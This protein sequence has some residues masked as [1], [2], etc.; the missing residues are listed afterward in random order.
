VHLSGAVYAET[1][2]RDAG[3]DQLC[4]DPLALAFT[5]PT[6]NGCLTNAVP[7]AQVP[8]NQHLYD[9]LID[10]FSMRS[11]VPTPG[12]S[13]HDHFFDTFAKFTG[14]DPK[15]IGEWI[16]EVAARAASQNEQYLELMDTPEFSHA[17][18]LSHQVPWNDDLAAY[19][20]ALLAA[21]LRDEVAVD[22]AHYD[23]AEATRNQIEHCGQANATP[24]CRVKVRYLYQILRGNPKEQVFAQTLLGFEVA[25]ADPRVVG[26]NYVMPEDGY[27]SMTDY[28]LHMQIV[29]YLHSV[30]PKVHISL[31]AGELAP[32]LVTYEGL[33][34]HIG[35]AVKQAHAERIGHGVD[36]MYENNPVDLLR[37]MASNHV[38]VEINLTSNDVILGVSGKD[39]PLPVYRKFNVPVALSTD[40]EGV[41]RI[42][43][44]HE[45]VRAAQAYSLSYA[46]LKKMARES[47]EHAFL[48]GQS[49]WSI[50]EDFTH[51]ATACAKD[52]LGAEKPSDACA[53][54]LK[55]NE[56]AGE[57]WDLESRF[58]VFE[59][60][61]ANP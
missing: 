37:D 28:A 60:S 33:C 13:G 16:D 11:W 20:S 24:A 8:S 58:R 31:H 2:I 30:Y 43:L 54:F 44:T 25:S 3:Q 46:D 49:L 15:H 9:Q 39:H 61:T 17:A 45:Y 35:L 41:S 38:M 26:I 7:A 51:P 6:V 52:P 59:S 47:I 29:G 42:N 55:Q 53:A 23:R 32:G 21:G 12:V 1:F 14:T 57:Q 34:C 36:I 40:D 50:P 56:K 27:T 19:R 5:R 22:R 48:P 4:V 10:S 18:L